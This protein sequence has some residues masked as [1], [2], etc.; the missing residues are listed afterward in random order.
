MTTE[1]WIFVVPCK[2]SCLKMNGFYAIADVFGKEVNVI[3]VTFVKRRK[4]IEKIIF[5]ILC[6]GLS[7][8]A[9]VCVLLHQLHQQV[10]V[11]CWLCSCWT[12]YLADFSK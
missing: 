2:N 10:R 7:F 3:Q 1:L 9:R 6:V 5:Q 12:S 8:W 11:N 4:V